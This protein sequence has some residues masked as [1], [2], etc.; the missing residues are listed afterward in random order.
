MSP[1]SAFV[2]IFAQVQSLLPSAAASPVA[3]GPH[4][5]WGWHIH[6]HDA[7]KGAVK[8]EAAW[9]GSGTTTALV[10]GYTDAQAC[11]GTGEGHP[12]YQLGVGRGGELAQCTPPHGHLGWLEHSSK[13]PETQRGRWGLPTAPWPGSQELLRFICSPV[14]CCAGTWAPAEP[15]SPGPEQIQSDCPAPWG[16]RTGKRGHRWHHGRGDVGGT[17]SWAQGH[18]WCCWR[19]A[20]PTTE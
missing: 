12:P 2:T 14:P 6:L 7:P 13:S 10:S 5:P 18:R 16:G 1:S 4:Q 19:V 17:A 15:A 11:P 20:A 3:S 8:G 9:G